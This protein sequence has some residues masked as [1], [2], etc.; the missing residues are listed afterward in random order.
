MRQ[1]FE[2]GNSSATSRHKGGCSLSHL[3]RGSNNGIPNTRLCIDEDKT[4][5]KIRVFYQ[6]CQVF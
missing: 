6:P 5:E 4:D 3:K 1:G 2:G